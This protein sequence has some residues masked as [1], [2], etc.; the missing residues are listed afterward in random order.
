MP[1]DNLLT[2]LGDQEDNFVERKPANPNRDDIRKTVVAFANTVS[3][4]R[5][6]ILFIGIRNDG[7]IEDVP[8]PDKLQKTVREVCEKDCYPPIKFLSEVVNTPKGKIVAVVISASVNRPHFAGPAFVRRGSESVTASAEIFDELVHSRNS[9]TAAIVKLKGQ[10]VSV[11]SL[12]HKLG[13]AKHIPGVAYREGTECR[14]EA[15]STHTVRLHIIASSRMVTEPLD[16]VTLSYD[17]AKWRPL[18]IISGYN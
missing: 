16:H 5:T 4:D 3:E 13:E 18:L 10:I 14:V 11:L 7:T 12:Q 9:K 15:A 17:E 8:N 6:G 2:R 1:N